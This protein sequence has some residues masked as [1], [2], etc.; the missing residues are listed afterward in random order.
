MFATAAV[1]DDARPPSAL[2]AAAEDAA[3]NPAV[4]ANPA[5]RTCSA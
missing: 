1:A 4:A 3:T 2:V 5:T